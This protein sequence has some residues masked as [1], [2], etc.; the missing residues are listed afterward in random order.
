MLINGTNL[1]LLHQGFA[2]TF[3]QG[4]TQAN[5][6]WSKVAMRVTSATA[7]NKY[8]WGKGFAGIREWIG[9]RHINKLGAHQFAIVN[10]DFENTIEVDRNTI[11]DDQYGVLEPVIRQL[12]M[13]TALFP[14]SLVYPLLAA[15]FTGLAYDGKAFFAT[16]HPVFDSA[17]VEQDV[18]NTDEGSAD[19]WFLI[20]A[21]KAYRP[22]VYQERQPFNFVPKDQD[23]DDNVFL[24]KSLLYG[25][26]GRA[27]AGY[28]LW[29]IAWGSKQPLTAAN[30]ATGRA[31][32]LKMTRDGGTRLGI[33]PTHLIVGPGNEAAA[34]RLLF[35]GDRLEEPVTDFWVA[36]SNE[37]ERSAELVV[38]PYLP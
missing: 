23:T 25:V 3:T 14:D 34:R 28:G 20:D 16:D 19:P 29:Q 18:A 30:Y 6:Q 9:D 13:D 2:A 37:W 11:A 36:R 22:I 27:N 17:G 12:G 10:K 15:G 38:S 7:E 26:D 5:P 32:L 4:I 35:G 24:R 21:S 31:A 1:A 8:A 33:T